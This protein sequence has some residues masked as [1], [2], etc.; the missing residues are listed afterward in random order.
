MAGEPVHTASK[1]IK[2]PELIFLSENEPQLSIT[3]SKVNGH[4]VLLSAMFSPLHN[5]TNEE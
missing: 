3:D 2:V 4:Y 5:A 1:E